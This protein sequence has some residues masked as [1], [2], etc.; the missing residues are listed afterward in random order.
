MQEKPDN[1]Y[2]RKCRKCSEWFKWH[3]ET[4]QTCPKCDTSLNKKLKKRSTKF[5]TSWFYE[6]RN[7]AFIRDNKTCRG[8]DITEEKAKIKYPIVDKRRNRILCCHHIDVNRNNNSLSNL[9]TLCPA[10]HQGL[11]MRYKAYELKDEWID[12]VLPKNGKWKR[13]PYPKNP[14]KRHFFKNIK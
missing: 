1:K 9:I 6:Q 8:C 5:D 11:H 13:K 12:D 14:P 3:T 4:K 2:Y 10:C 7:K